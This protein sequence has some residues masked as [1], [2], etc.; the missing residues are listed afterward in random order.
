MWHAFGRTS[1]SLR[2]LRTGDLTDS[3]SMQNEGTRPEQRVSAPARIKIAAA[4]AN[5]PHWRDLCPEGGRAAQM[6]S[7]RECPPSLGQ[8]GKDFGSTSLV[9]ALPPITGVS[10]IVQIEAETDVVLN[11][12]VSSN[13]LNEQSRVKPFL[14]LFQSTPEAV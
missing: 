13:L 10:V 3:P 14:A 1:A 8:P 9:E 5:M 12:N 11:L 7:L 6:W 2:R 4:C